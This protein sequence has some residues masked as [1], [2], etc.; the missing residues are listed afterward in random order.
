MP[1]SW[2]TLLTFAA[3]I[4]LVTAARTER[5]RAQDG[6]CPVD[7]VPPP[8]LAEGIRAA[9]HVHGEFDIVATTNWTRFYSALYLGLVHDAMERRPEG[10]VLFFPAESL[11]W[12]FFAVSGLTDTSKAPADLLWSRQLGAGTWLAYRPGGIVRKVEKGSDPRL[13]VN[14]RIS[15]PDR[16]DGQDNYTFFDTVSVPQLKVTNR[17]VITFRQLDF[18]DMVVH[19]KIEGV[20]ARPLTGLL[21]AFFSL[22]GEGSIKYSRSAVAPDGVQV[23]RVKAKRVFSV[24]ATVTVYP[25]GR[26][27][28]DLP[29]SRPDL[30]A[31]EERLKQDL[32]IEYHPYRCW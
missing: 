5:A 24:T 2:R 20:S 12:E 16:E 32:E 1:K 9:A 26:G 4:P 28:K 7:T 30:A 14:V 17:R 13:A 11:F 21:A 23:M 8:V 3:L 19:D 27:E 25:D 22:I 6:A 29:E 31:I 15:W 18:G 10:G